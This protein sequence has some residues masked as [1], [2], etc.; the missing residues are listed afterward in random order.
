MAVE[1]VIG[2]ALVSL[3]AGLGI[4]FFLPGS[5]RSGKIKVAQLEDALATAQTELTDY[6]REVLGQ[7]ADT[8]EKFHA[9]DK[10][11]HD[12]H[13]QLAASSVALC[14]DAAT[15]LLESLDTTATSEGEEAIVVAEADTGA[16][17]EVVA[18][19]DAGQ[20]PAEGP[21]DEPAEAP[22]HKGETAAPAPA[23]EDFRAEAAAAEGV[24]VETAAQ[25]E[26]SAQEEEGDGK[27]ALPEGS[28]FQAGFEDTLK[29]DATVE[30]VEVE[31]LDP[32]PTLTEVDSEEPPA[33]RES[34]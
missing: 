19:E 28:D 14:G 6:K 12:L 34:A 11:Y 17:S 15:P 22:L 18:A 30:S 24:E 9:L 25:E 27:P 23:S 3:L 26:S 2:I 10:S 33:R 16:E 7:F 31:D 32:V 4:G 20:E 21:V 1:M 13:R 8:A 5:G 29:V